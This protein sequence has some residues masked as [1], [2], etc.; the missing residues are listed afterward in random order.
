[1]YLRARACRRTRSTTRT[2]SGRP[3]TTA[4][5]PRRC[6]PACPRRWSTLAAAGLP[7][8]LV[9]AG[10]RSDR[11]AADRAA[12]AS[13]RS[14]AGP[15]VR[16]RPRRPEARPGATAPRARRDSV[17]PARRPRSSTS[18][19]RRTTCGWPSRPACGRSASCRRSATARRC[20]RRAPRRWSTRCTRGPRFLATG[21]VGGAPWRRRT[22]P[23]ADAAT[24][25][26]A[27]IVAD[28]DRPDLA[29]LD[30]T[31]PGWRDGVALIVAADGGAR[32]RGPRARPS[33]W[34]SG[35]AIRSA[36][37]ALAEL[38]AAGIAVECSPADK[39]E[40]DTELA[41]LACL[42]RGATRHHD[43][44]RLRRP[45]G[46]RA[47]EHLAARAA[48]PRRPARGTAGRSDPGPIA[49]CPGPRRRTGPA[50]APRSR[51]ATSSRCCRS[52]S[53]VEGIT[54][55]AFATRSVTSRCA[56]VRRVACPTSA[57]DGAAVT[58]RRGL[59]LIVESPSLPA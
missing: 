39:D 8:A 51:R 15:G 40:S 37:P 27:L 52:E 20:S 2:R 34:S 25:V 29:A 26:H 10:A 32:R 33:I 24:P 21:S 6:C 30:A 22:P 47:R 5:G 3:P 54:T 57:P 59:L 19:T 45:A 7:L 58:V 12:R 44:R 13:T 42:A 35:T 55:E 48:G 46:S 56:S 16:G 50:P 17:L 11:R 41:V 1:M 53:D 49:P 38:V 23:R 28:G 9:T 31:W 14:A 18:A 4:R 43:R 36:R